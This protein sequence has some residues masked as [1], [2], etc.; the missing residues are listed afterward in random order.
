[1]KDETH[2]RRILFALIGLLL[3]AGCAQTQTT[4]PDEVTLQLKWLHGAQFAGFYMADTNGY[5]A[6]ENIVVEMRPGGF[7]VADIDEVVSGNAH[8][9][10]QPGNSLLASRDAGQSL[11]AVAAIFQINPT[12]YFSLAELG[13][14]KPADMAGRRVGYNETDLLLPAVLHSAGLS[15]DDIETYPATFDLTPLL[16]GK[17]DVWVGYVTT[18]VLTLQAQGYD[19]NIIRAYDYG[20]FIYSDLLF[21]TDDLIENNPDLVERFV[22]ASLRGWAYALEHPDEAVDAI[23]QFNPEMERERAQAELLATVPLITTPQSGLGEMEALVWQTTHDIM[24]DSGLIAAPIQL[25]LIYTNTFVEGFE[26]S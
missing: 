6:E 2:M 20:A 3:L 23:L 4:P 9:G 1:M 5:Y 22:R 14:E 26:P 17:A 11:K 12:A 24:L 18:A 15:L 7:D 25:D 21:T 8:F 19:L 16:E 13:I 10:L